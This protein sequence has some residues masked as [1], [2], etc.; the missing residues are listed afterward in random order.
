MSKIIG[1]N[2]SLRFPKA[3]KLALEAIEFSIRSGKITV[4]LGVSGSG[5]TTLLKCISGLL[6]HHDGTLS[7]DGVLKENLTKAKRIKAIGYVSQHYQLFPHMNVYQ[8]CTHPQI[9]VLK[10]PQNQ[11]CKTTDHFLK[12][13]D[14]AHLKASYPSELSGGQQQRVAIARAL[15]MGPQALLFDEPTSALD[16]E[17]TQKLKTVLLELKNEGHTIVITTHDT[18]FAQLIMDDV[19]FMQNGCLIE[20]F[21]SN[22]IPNNSKTY[23]FLNHYK[24][25]I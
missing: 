20:A 9:K 16:P 6:N 14:L 13:F 1:K 12:R 7:Y 17:S 8:N 5:K 25:I 4:F 22:K 15:G 10:K 18:T 19:C 24:E 23:Q 21:C 2:L 3:S 11:A